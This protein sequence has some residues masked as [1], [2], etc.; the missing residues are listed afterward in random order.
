MTTLSDGWHEDRVAVEGRAVPVRVYRKSVN[1]RCLTLDADTI[2]KN[3]ASL[4]AE[5]AMF[6]ELLEGFAV[7][8]SVAG[9][10]RR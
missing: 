1:N 4:L 7:A 9:S 3:R 5:W 10:G 2:D 8:G 6:C